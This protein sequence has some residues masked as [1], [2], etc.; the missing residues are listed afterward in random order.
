MSALERAIGLLQTMTENKLEAVYRYMRFAGTQM[1]NEEPSAD[2]EKMQAQF[3]EL[4]INMP[5]SNKD[6]KRQVYK[7]I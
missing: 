4:P 5:I 1:E 6:L 2:K 7:F 3:W